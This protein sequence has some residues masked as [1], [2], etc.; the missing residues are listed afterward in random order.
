MSF[1][2]K[3]GGFITS[4]KLWI[5]I[6]LILF[7][8]VLIIWGSLK[9]FDSYT[10]H[11]QEIQVP[12]LL[13]NNL[14]DVPQLLT[15]LELRYEVIDSIYDPS[16]LEGTV[17]YQS[18]M[19]TDSTGMG[20]K[21]GR[22]IKVRV[23]KQTRL[24]DLPIVVSKSRRFA[25]TVLMTKGLRTK[26]TFVPSNE[27]QGSVIEQRYRGKAVTKG[28]KIPINSIIELVVGQKTGAEFAYVPDLSGLT[29]KEAEERLRGAGGLRLFAIY[30]DCASNQ[31]SLMARIMNQ[32]PVTG[33]SSKV[34]YGS[35]ITVFA[36]PTL[37]A[38]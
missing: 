22:V 9:Y 27:D 3:L 34:P 28:M 16:L 15:G 26:T 25:E 4:R 23:S 33:D 30:N 6:G 37:Q 29:I 31:D 17:V 18:P 13:G 32:T 14:D 7:A 8:W 11:G 5:N 2:H 1:I 24:V 12:V 35:T 19:P 36:S 38:D 10:N 20:V 21:E